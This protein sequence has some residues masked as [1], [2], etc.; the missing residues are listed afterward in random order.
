MRWKWEDQPLY[1]TLEN[2]SK[3]WSIVNVFHT[4]YEIQDEIIAPQASVSA[5]NIARISH[6]GIVRTVHFR[7]WQRL[8]YSRIDVW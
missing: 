2:P 3:A 7:I 1:V 4:D 5:K 6:H 8:K